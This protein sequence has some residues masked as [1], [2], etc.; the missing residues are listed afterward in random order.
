MLKSKTNLEGR[1]FSLLF[2]Q[3][4]WGIG[5]A[6]IIIILPFSTSGEPVED[7][8]NWCKNLPFVPTDEDDPNIFHF[9]R[10]NYEPLTNRRD[11]WNARMDGDEHLLHYVRSVTNIKITM[12]PTTQQVVS[13]ESSEEIFRRPFLFMTGEYDF[14][15]NQGAKELFVEFFKRG[16]FLYADDCVIGGYGDNFY[17]SFVREFQNLGPDFEMKEAPFDHPIYHCFFDFERGAPFVQG[18][19]HRDMGIFYK[20][21]LVA[22]LT[23]GDVHCGYTGFWYDTKPELTEDCLKIVTNII[24]YALTH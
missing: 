8:Q 14:S 2:F 15:M 17:K 16:G 20:D 22:F 11:V 21:K 24:V 4:L 1:R 3:A 9:P 6:A 18:Q 19:Q 12:K 7:L 10:L 13:L 23:S 5:F